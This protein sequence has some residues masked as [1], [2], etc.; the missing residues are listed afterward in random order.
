MEFF[1]KL[2]DEIKFAIVALVVGNIT[3]LSAAIRAKIEATFFKGAFSNAVEAINEEGCKSCAQAAKTRNII[4]GIE[5][6]VNPVVVAIKD[7]M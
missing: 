1:N 6:K 7:S 5:K 4:D 3:L 2:P